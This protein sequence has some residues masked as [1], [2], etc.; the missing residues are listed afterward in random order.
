MPRPLS[1][2]QW[3]QNRRRLGGLMVIDNEP[4]RQAA[5]AIYRQLEA[6]T[7]ELRAQV[8]RFET[9]DR[10]AYE[11]WEARTFGL[12][13]T[14]LREV[15]AALGEKHHI[16]EEIDEEMYWSN[17]SRLTAYRRV[18]KQ[19]HEP[20][21][22]F[23][24]DNWEG[25]SD[26][27]D[28]PEAQDP[29]DPEF[30]GAAGLFG[31]SHLPPG[32]RIED[33]DR[34]RGS[35]KREFREFYEMMAQ[36][37]EMTTGEP[38]PVLEDV[39]ARERSRA[40][41]GR[42]TAGN[43][44]RAAFPHASAQLPQAGREKDRLRELYRRLVRQLHPDMN[45]EFG[46]REREF[47]C[48]IQ[49]AYRGRD[50]ERLEAIAARIEIGLSSASR[51]VPVG[52]L[53]RITRDLRVAQES[54]RRQLAQLKREPAWRFSKRGEDL[55]AFEARRRR[56]LER[57]LRDI[58]REL[59]ECTAVLDELARRAARPPKRRGA[60]QAAPIRTAKQMEFF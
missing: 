13:L 30:G 33:Y 15:S 38:A 21:E 41:T 48:E 22:P 32:F 17:C 52:I 11:R 27:V 45:G 49:A 28:P 34:M 56:Q 53:L 47:W 60:K 5:L 4:I 16:L 18:M 7:G 3:H 2:R 9:A 44:G 42:E 54:L 12:L 58:R 50:L 10:P 43:C 36:M 19:L 14:E 55:A 24:E 25:D 1:P 46:S 37:Y 29:E 26:R 57:E 59:L 20:S 51:E 6:E 31:A 8:E 23:G 35:E 40:G 39:L